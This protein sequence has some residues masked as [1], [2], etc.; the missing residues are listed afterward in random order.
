MSP[1]GEILLLS[2]VLVMGGA[3]TSAL[4]QY[5]SGAIPV[6]QPDHHFPI[7]YSSVIPVIY[8]FNL[9]VWNATTMKIQFWAKHNN[10]T[11]S[12]N[13]EVKETFLF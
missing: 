4:E 11:E 9:P 3:A 2:V 13:Y 6:R 1:T 12:D 7:L 10:C 8:K 5:M